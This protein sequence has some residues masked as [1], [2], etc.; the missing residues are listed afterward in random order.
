[1]PPPIAPTTAPLPTPGG[2]LIAVGKITTLQP[3]IAAAPVTAS[4]ADVLA[5]ALLYERLIRVD[6]RTSEPEPGL[7]AWEIGAD[8]RTYTWRIPP[9]ASW[10]DGKP[11][12]AADI[13]TGLQAVA[14]S[15]IAARLVTIFAEIEGFR[16]YAQGS[17]TTIAGVRLDPSDPKRLTVRLERSLCPSLVNVFGS[18]V[19]LPTH[20]F[21]K[22]LVPDAAD[23]IDRAPEND[24]PRV[25]SGP[26]VLGEWRRGDQ[27]SLVRNTSYWRGAPLLD[28]FIFREGGA[29]VDELR[30]GTVNFGGVTEPIEIAGAITTYRTR[31][32]ASTYQFIGWNTQSESAP[33]LRDKRVRQAL[34]YGLDWELLFRDVVKDGTRVF[35]HHLPASWAHPSGLNEYR[36][37]RTRA[38][39]LL[40]SAGYVKGADGIARKDGRALAITITTNDNAM[41]KS[42]V[43]LAV[44]QYADLG[45]TVTPRII[46][47]AALVTALQKGDSSIDAWVAGLSHGDDP[48][49][50]VLWHSSLQA[51]PAIGRR[52]PVG[53]M[54]FFAPGLDEAIEQARNGPDCSLTRRKEHYATFDRILNEE[55][56]FAFGFT[57]AKLDAGPVGLNEFVSAS[58]NLAAGYDIHRWWIAPGSK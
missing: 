58:T 17:A 35:T 40:A 32:S 44:T 9:N 36:Y 51:D 50:F 38:E 39:G 13:V 6:P 11:V 53:Q 5:T 31:T 28:G 49:P 18:V 42:I 7:A 22:Y 48:D 41:R 23:A 2:R 34:A 26:F 30:K 15:K 8:G 33:A 12:V 55:Q 56:P 19:V 27:L 45:I 14:K 57:R 16:A 20:V 37:D 43:Q 47:F 24:E 3:L 54:P 10:T 52:H 25:T 1:M 29:L 4:S 21:G 46:D